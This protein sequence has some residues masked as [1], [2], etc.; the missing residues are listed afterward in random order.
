MGLIQRNSEI[1]GKEAINYFQ[2]SEK[3][4]PKIVR[5]L[6]VAEAP[7][8]AGTRYFYVPRRMS[9]KT[10]VEKDRSLPATIFHHYFKKKPE[11]VEEYVRF[12]NKL[13][14]LGIFVVDI[15][16]API[17]IREKGGINQKNL[18]Y[19]VSKIKKLRTKIKRRGIFIGDENII[20]LLPRRHYKKELHEEFPNSKKMRWIDFRLSSE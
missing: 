2:E 16:D 17:K 15:L 1:M 13:R 3:Y 5:T 4:R 7:P 11:T 6:L 20:F 10:P 19:L 12:L 14:D 8:P 9:N 18:Q